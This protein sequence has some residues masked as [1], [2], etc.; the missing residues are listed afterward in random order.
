VVGNYYTAGVTINLTNLVS[1]APNYDGNIFFTLDYDDGV[2]ISLQGRQ[3]LNINHIFTDYY[4]ASLVIGF[5]HQAGGVLSLS[6]SN[7]SG[8]KITSVSC[9]ITNFYCVDHGPVG[10]F[11]L[12]LF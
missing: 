1:V 3:T 9:P 5:Q 7:A 4:S 10:S 12:A 6:L 2:T 8:S 11:G